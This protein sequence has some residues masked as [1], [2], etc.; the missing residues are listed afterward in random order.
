MPTLE[1]VE[2]CITDPPYLLDFMGKE[3]DN[4]NI[5]PAFG[6]WLAG[7]A[8]GEG[9]FTVHKAHGG[10][11]YTCA[12]KINLRLDDRAILETIHRTLGIG[13]IRK[14]SACGT[15]KPGFEWAVQK[16]S[17]CL[18]LA[19]LFLTFPLRAKKHRDF[20]KWYEALLA[21]C[22]AGR[23]NRWHGPADFSEV[24]AIKQ[25][26]QAIREY[27]EK[28]PPINK[29]TF[30]HYLWA[31]SL[32]KLLKPGAIALVFGGTRTFHRLAMWLH[33]QGFP[34]S[35]NISKAID[36]KAGAER[37]VVG[38]R[39]KRTANEIYGGGKGT[40]TETIE[41]KAA[42]PEAKQWEGWGTALKPAW[43]SLLLCQKPLDLPTLLSTA[44]LASM[45]TV[46][47]YRRMVGRSVRR[48]A[49]PGA[50]PTWTAAGPRRSARQ[51]RAAGQLT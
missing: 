31:K 6:N 38:I 35:H 1:P 12:F 44:W 7:F 5:D 3:W 23:G 2:T 49:R 27:K 22:R 14:R 34:K 37:E 11:S 50:A 8:D 15:A 36:K 21:L 45:S 16:R 33:G 18:R 30:F 26:L 48:Q 28:P 9:C 39:W 42:T 20:L 24:K 10:N 32:A 17:E 43:E 19:R 41:D 4:A 46:H 25:E 29:N 40:N 51:R 13:T 47:G